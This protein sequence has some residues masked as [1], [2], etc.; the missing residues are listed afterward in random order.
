MGIAVAAVVACGNHA[1]KPKGTDAAGSGSG[2][3]MGTGTGTDQIDAAPAAPGRVEHAVY[4]L[5]D[6][7][8]M[9]HRLV[10]GDLVVDA[11]TAGV[12]RYHRFGLPTPRW[13]L[14]V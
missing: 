3:G 13:R 5:G 6:N 8:M 9:A 12:A 4:K 14:D 10:D 11:S 7:R 1:A 2:T